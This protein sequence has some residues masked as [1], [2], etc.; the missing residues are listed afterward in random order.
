MSDTA[1]VKV[2][3]IVDEAPAVR[4][5]WDPEV[6]SIVWHGPVPYMEK[7]DDINCKSGKGEKG[8]AR[9]EAEKAVQPNK[10]GCPPITLPWVEWGVFC[11]LLFYC[12]SKTAS[13]PPPTNLPLL[14][15]CMYSRVARVSTAQTAP[16]SSQVSPVI[17]FWAA[18][19]EGVLLPLASRR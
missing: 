18:S 13:C 11:L 5:Q 6:S 3:E 10:E 17:P 9:K 8:V 4:L 7:G 14:K 2:C 16:L 12:I 1:L 19:S 15:S